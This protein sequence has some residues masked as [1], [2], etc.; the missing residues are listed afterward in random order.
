MKRGNGGVKTNTE[1][2][3]YRGKERGGES[4]GPIRQKAG[5]VQGYCADLIK[6]GAS[7]SLNSCD[8]VSEFTVFNF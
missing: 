3:T 6:N 7:P 5:C 1:K 8:E 2:L 4:R